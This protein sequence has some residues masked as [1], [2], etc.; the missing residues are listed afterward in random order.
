ML[1][2]LLVS[3]RVAKEP[4]V[5]SLLDCSERW[6]NPVGAVMLIGCEPGGGVGD[7]QRGPL[8]AAGV[9]PAEVP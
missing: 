5:K 3:W 9:V 4:P 1:V 7:P 2:S 8:A 6:V